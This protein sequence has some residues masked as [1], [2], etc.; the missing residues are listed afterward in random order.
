MPGAPKGWCLRRRPKGYASRNLT[1]SHYAPRSQRPNKNVFNRRL[2]CSKLMSVCLRWAGRLFHSLELAVAK[3]VSIAAVGPS[4]DTSL[5]WQ[6]AA[7]DDLRRRPDDSRRPGKL[8]P[9]RTVSCRPV[10]PSWS[11]PDAEPEASLRLRRRP[12]AYAS[13]FFS[14]TKRWNCTYLCIFNS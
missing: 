9:C 1:V 2:N 10:W 4:D 5:N 12:E 11:P 8:E 3:H 14:K 13:N 6:N 7:D